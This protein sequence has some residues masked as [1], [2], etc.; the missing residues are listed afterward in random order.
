M[1][2]TVIATIGFTS[3]AALGLLYLINNNEKEVRPII[4]IN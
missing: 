4:P 1:D 2:I 3:L